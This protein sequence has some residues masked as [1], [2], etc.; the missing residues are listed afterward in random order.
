MK[1][2]E[3]LR[4]CAE[5]YKTMTKLGVK[6]SDCER[7]GMWEEYKELMRESGKKSYA[8]AVISHRH[9]LSERTV[10]RI[11]NRLERTI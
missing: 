7:L 1:V 3:F 10:L 9:Q 8:V 2:G 4:I 11:I 6:P 5:Q